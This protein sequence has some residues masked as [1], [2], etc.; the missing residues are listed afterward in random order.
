MLREC[1]ECFPHHWLQWKPLVSNP[2]MHH[3]TCVMHVPWW[4]SG[5]LPHGGRENVPSIH[6]ACTTPKFTYLAKGSWLLNLHSSKTSIVRT[7]QLCKSSFGTECYLKWIKWVNNP[8]FTVAPFK[9]RSGSHGIETEL[10]RYVR[11]ICQILITEYV[12]PVIWLK[13]N[14]ILLV[15]AKTTTWSEHYLFTNCGQEENHYLPI[16]PIEQNNL[17]NGMC[18]FQILTWIGKC[19]HHSFANWIMH[20]HTVLKCYFILCMYRCHI[21]RFCNK[22]PSGG[23]LYKVSPHRRCQLVSSRC[24]EQCLHLGISESKQSELGSIWT[25]YDVIS[26]FLCLILCCWNWCRYTTFVNMSRLCINTSF[27]ASHRNYGDWRQ[28]LMCVALWVDVLSGSIVRDSPSTVI[29]FKLI[30]PADIVLFWALL[31]FWNVGRPWNEC[32]WN[33]FPIITLQP[34]PLFESL[35]RHLAISQS[36][37]CLYRDSR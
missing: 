34:R 6:G 17:F 24:I 1:R 19:I 9:L 8:K 29:I 35:R 5:L 22:Q 18:I 23:K 31:I 16:Q 36:D 25:R 2:G 33:W 37:G 4:M 10:D 14:N 12:C 26:T 21:R 13:T 28:I 15:L 7:C 3:G 27:G 11:Q 32:L 20:R 30:S